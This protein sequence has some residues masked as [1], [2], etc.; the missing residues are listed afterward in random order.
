MPGRAGDQDLPNDDN[1]MRLLMQWRI[2]AKVSR[3]GCWKE[4]VL[5]RQ[6]CLSRGQ[7]TVPFI[8]ALGYLG[9]LSTLSI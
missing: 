5:Q 2:G 3:R 7:V 6:V 9:Y 4:S 1:Q 8:L